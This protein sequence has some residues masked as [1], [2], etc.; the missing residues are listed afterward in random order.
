MNTL[1]IIKVTTRVKNE[2]N[3]KTNTQKV[4][5]EIYKYILYISGYHSLPQTHTHEYTEKFCN[6]L[7][8]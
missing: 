5:N 6:I 1:G 8:S 7:H 4:E 2:T 3:T